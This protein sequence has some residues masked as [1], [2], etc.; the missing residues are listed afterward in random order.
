MTH[1]IKLTGAQQL[2]RQAFLNNCSEDALLKGAK[3]TIAKGKALEDEGRERLAAK[4][5]K[6]T[7]FQ[8]H[9]TPRYPHNGCLYPGGNPVA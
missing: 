5:K 2:A 4:R 8:R 3:E 1:Q 6:I 7:P 9:T